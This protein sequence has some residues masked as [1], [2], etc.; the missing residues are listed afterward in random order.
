VC[1][2]AYAFVS[3]RESTPRRPTEE[4]VLIKGRPSPEE[5]MSRLG[6]HLERIKRLGVS[7]PGLGDLRKT[8]LEIEFEEKTG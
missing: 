2:S 7:G 8:Y 6:R 3:H 1:C 4:G 5:V